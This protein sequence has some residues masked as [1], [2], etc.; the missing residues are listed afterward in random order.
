MAQI[1]VG[2]KLDYL[3][4]DDSIQALNDLKGSER[5][6]PYGA[7]SL[8]PPVRKLTPQEVEKAQDLGL[9]PQRK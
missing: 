6:L 9:P 8:H 4:F 1:T 2:G 3:Y 7:N 5:I